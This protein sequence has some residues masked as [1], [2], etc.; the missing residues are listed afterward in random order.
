MNNVYEI[1]GCL[2]VCR[3]QRLTG[4]LFLNNL[5]IKNSGEIILETI[6]YCNKRTKKIKKEQF[7][8]L[9]LSID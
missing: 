2:I 1:E 7:N 3:L 9:T 8:T 6:Y 5:L 4:L